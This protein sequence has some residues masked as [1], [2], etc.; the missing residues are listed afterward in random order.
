[1]RSSAFFTKQ[2]GVNLIG[3]GVFTHIYEWEGCFLSQRKQII[4][5]VITK[6]A[7]PEPQRWVRDQIL[8]PLCPKLN[9]LLSCKGCGRLSGRVR[10]LPGHSACDARCRARTGAHEL[11][12]RHLAR[13][14]GSFMMWL[15][16]YYAPRGQYIYEWVCTN[17]QSVI[18]FNKK[19][20]VRWINNWCVSSHCVVFPTALISRAR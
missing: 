2:T 15:F 14:L 13:S 17:I 6:H 8:E 4:L 7:V 1:L 20:I 11:F 10:L 3:C 5:G 18:V 16:P 9:V 19:S 12:K